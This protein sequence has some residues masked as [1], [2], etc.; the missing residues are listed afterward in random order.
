[1]KHL[2]ITPPI[3][4]A[5]PQ[6]LVFSGRGVN[7]RQTMTTVKGANQLRRLCLPYNN[8]Y[9]IN[10]YLPT[11]PAH[12]SGPGNMVYL[13]H[14]ELH[15]CSVK[16]LAAQLGEDRTGWFQAALAP[17]EGPIAACT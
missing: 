5:V 2:L 13:H 6:L 16:E 4:Q 8:N 17:M 1:M 12:Q 9:S 3:K 11:A 14:K 7:E 15:L 10:Q